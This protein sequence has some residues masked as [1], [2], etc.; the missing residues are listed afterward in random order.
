MSIKRYPTGADLVCL[1]CHKQA[2][3]IDHVVNRGQG[4]SKARDVPENKVPLCRECHE[5]K[6][7]GRI[8]TEIY[9]DAGGGLYY[10]WQRKTDGAPWI[11]TAVKI[12]KRY[13]CLVQ[14]VMPDASSRRDGNVG[15]REVGRDARPLSDGAEAAKSGS[16]IKSGRG[17]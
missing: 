10:Q 4:G 6:T 12:S 13:K 17:N 3:D 11:I 16:T 2:Q 8:M 1:V 14:E 5:L 7:Q 15:E 9:A